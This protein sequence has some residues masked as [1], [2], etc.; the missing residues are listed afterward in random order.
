MQT[1]L[2][3]TWEM[4]A[5]VLV[6]LTATSMVHAQNESADS[7]LFDNYLGTFISAKGSSLKIATDEGEKT[8]RLVKPDEDLPEMGVGRGTAISVSGADTITFL[9]PA[10]TVT[11]ETELD[12]NSHSSNPLERI[13]VIALSAKQDTSKEEITEI[14]PE[15]GLGSY[16]FEARIQSVDLQ[17]NRL[18]VLVRN[19]SKSE[20]YELALDP[21][22]TQVH[23]DLPDLSLAQPGESIL[24]RCLPTNGEKL[25]AT[26]V[27]VTRPNPFG[28]DPAE[29]G[30]APQAN[31]E[32]ETPLDSEAMEA[33]ATDAANDGVDGGDEM[34]GDEEDATADSPDKTAEEKDADIE[35]DFKRENRPAVKI[36]PRV[37]EILL[38]VSE[39]EPQAED[40]VD[41]PIGPEKLNRQS[42][43]KPRPADRTWHKIN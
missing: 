15:T 38:G 23:Y 34:L 36:D 35:F 20:R 1:R 11:F 26:E 32:P 17:R 30:A 43:R 7:L 24:V 29:E 25:F 33:E 19:G 8:F 42:S 27:R 28:E 37:L 16:R 6:I 18:G 40:D 41:V 5:V 14:D 12:K 31:V 13:D 9:K 4:S 22:T 39:G 3:W 10:M 21:K 2:R